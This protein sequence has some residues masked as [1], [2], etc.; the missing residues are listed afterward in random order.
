LS[1]VYGFVTVRERGGSNVDLLLIEAFVLEKGGGDNCC[2]VDRQ[3]K[4]RVGST[5][6]VLTFV[7]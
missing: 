6:G 4:G 3:L 1:W 5:M 2:E 7:C